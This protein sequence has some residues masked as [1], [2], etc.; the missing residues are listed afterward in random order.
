MF[1]YKIIAL[2]LDGTLLTSARLITARTQD[3][4]LRLQQE[5]CKVVISTG[6]PVFGSA[7]IADQ[8]HLNEYGGFIMAYNGGVV[9]NWQTKEIIY[10]NM[11]LSE[12]IVESYQ[13]AKS[14]GLSIICYHDE[15]LV[16]DDEMNPYME[17]TLKR[18][19]LTFKKVSNF[20]EEVTYPISKCMIIG[21]PVALHELEEGILA[22]RPTTFTVYRSEPYFLEVVP[23]HI[24]KAEG[25]K[26]LLQHLSIPA[27]QLIAFGDNFNDVPMIRLAGMGVAMGNA[28]QEVKDSADA[29][30]PTND[31]EG[32]AFFLSQ[33]DL[34][35]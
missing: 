7:R 23:P 27:H 34:Y 30:A 15:F 1:G 20:L 25:L 10:S 32:I 16:S 19:G 11:L 13:F 4:L 31:E 8:L 33:K 14:A 24:N 3:I 9:Q 29:V 6:R 2:D 35:L 17:R 21:E 18:N 12:A 28:P 22:S 26:V 5:G